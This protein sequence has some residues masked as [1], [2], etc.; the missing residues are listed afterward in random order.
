[1][2]KFYMQVE[3]VNLSQFVYD[4][5]DISTIRGGSFLL[6]EAIE[7]LAAAFEGRLTQITAAASR[8]IFSLLVDKN[9]DAPEEFVDKLMTDVL[10]H[11]QDV[12]DSHATF[13]V[14][15]EKDEGVFPSILEI[16][17]MISCTTPG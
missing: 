7:G 17:L 4:T 16:I 3:A 5:H 14:A 10:Q 6:L 11:L 9:E 8:G 1:M 12:T 15:V 13:L 2:E